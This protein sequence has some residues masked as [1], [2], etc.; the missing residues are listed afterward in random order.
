MD[1]L[2]NGKL[3]DVMPVTYDEDGFLVVEGAEPALERFNLHCGDDQ[4]EMT[5]VAFGRSCQE[6]ATNGLD[7][8][9]QSGVH[10]AVQ[11]DLIAR[12]EKILGDLEGGNESNTVPSLVYNWQTAETVLADSRKRL[13]DGLLGSDANHFP[14]HHILDT[15][16]DARH[17]QRCVEAEFGE[18]IINPLVGVATAGSAHILCACRLLEFRITNGGTNG[19][20]VRVFVT[21]YECLHAIW[22]ACTKFSP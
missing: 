22:I 16:P 11:A 21:N 2:L 19:I 12:W 7:D 20:H 6:G 3:L 15:R 17:E 9:L 18:R 10:L 14:I 1:F 8:I 13:V 5:Y 4:D